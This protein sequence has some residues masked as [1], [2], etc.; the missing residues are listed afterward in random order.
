MAL[1]DLTGVKYINSLVSTNPVGAT[2]Y[3]SDG[4]DHIRGI[5][6]VLLQTFANITGAVTASHT[7][8]NYTDIT[9]AGTAEAS[10]A[11]VL[12]GSKGISTITSATITTLTSTTIFQSGN[13]VV[14]DGDIGVTVQAYDLDLATIAL[15][16]NADGNF[17]VGDG[18]QWIVESGA[19]ARA[20]LGFGA[21]G[22]FIVAGDIAASAVGNSELAANAVTDAEIDWTL[23]AAGTWAVTTSGLVIGAGIFM[24]SN[25]V[26]AGDAYVQVNDGASWDGIT[27]GNPFNGGVIMS[28]GTNVR[29][30]CASGTASFT[31]RQLA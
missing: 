25:I 17:I 3:V 27:T 4:D 29:L 28:D 16:S 6:N 14:D 19:T 2:D 7:Q 30:I 24:A 11:L 22:N 10:K 15:L 26:G 20:S 13:N 21:S 18:A 31:Y 12:D 9:A 5:K 23:G 8:L 1:E